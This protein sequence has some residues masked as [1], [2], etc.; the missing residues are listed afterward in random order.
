MVIELLGP[1]LEDLFQFSDRQFSLKTVLMLADQMISRI[2]FVH[3][4][5]FLHRDIKPDNF[6][7]GMG[8]RGHVVY[9]ID[10]GLGKRYRDAHKQHMPY[11]ENKSLTGTARYASIN[12]HAGKEQSRR[13]DLESLGY[14]LMYFL[15]GS[16]PW[17]G[18]KANTRKQKYERISEVK[19]STSVATLCNG[20]PAEFEEYFLYV[21]GLQFMGDPDYLFCRNIFRK[22]F[23]RKNFVYDYMFDWN[24]TV[25]RKDV[26]NG[27]PPQASGGG[28]SI[29]E[30][31]A[32]ANLNKSHQQQQYQTQPHTH[33]QQAPQ[34]QQQQHHQQ[35]QMQ[36]QAQQQPPQ[37]QI[38]PQQ[39]QQQQQ[40]LQQ[41]LQ[42]KMSGTGTR[43]MQGGGG[44]QQ[45][46]PIPGE[47]Q[48]QVQGQ[49]QVSQNQGQVQPRGPH[50]TRSQ[51]NL[52]QAQL[53]NESQP[54]QQQMSAAQAHSMQHSQLAQQQQ[55]QMLL[56]KERQAQNP[57]MQ[58]QDYSY[59]RD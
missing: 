17:Q 52:R 5:N 13:D 53:M 3:S 24:L 28:V 11:R 46:Q 25:Q 42:P 19:M 14:V 20:F 36:L 58:Q 56:N 32:N 15:R 31:N 45:Q 48:G 50:L 30:Q 39:Q 44:R 6:L 7:M 38:P 4:R 12:T 35:H 57:Q 27:A 9:V 22:L 51:Y 29:A 1:S 40:P 23:A 43:Q 10:F 41:P 2:E 16:L 8:R 59:R 33:Q 47:V 37:Q 54:Q 26:A 55:Q 49:G 21:R 18:L 34:Q